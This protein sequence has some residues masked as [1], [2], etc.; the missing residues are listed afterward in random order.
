MRLQT[1]KWFYLGVGWLSLGLGVV[2][3]VLPLL[4]TT[5]FLLLSAFA[6][7]RGS[8]R[9]HR[10]LLNHQTLGPP[11]AAWRDHRAV[12]R[13]AKVSATASLLALLLISA[14]IGVPQ[15]VVGLQTVILCGVGTFLWTR[16]EPPKETL[17]PSAEEAE[18]R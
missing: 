6:F 2:G 14:L 3:I 5:P 18:K 16:P 9:L 4:P 10:W 17:G 8:E 7:S 11:I 15:W 12:S 13:G 1:A